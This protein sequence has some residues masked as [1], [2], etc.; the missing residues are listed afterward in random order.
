MTAGQIFYGGLAV[1]MG[2]WMAVNASKALRTGRVL[3]GESPF[4]NSATKANQPAL[5][6]L[7]VIAQLIGALVGIAA[8]ACAFLLWG[9]N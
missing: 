6:W 2:I 9:P 8:G 5:Y 7:I 4:G 3:V 1:L